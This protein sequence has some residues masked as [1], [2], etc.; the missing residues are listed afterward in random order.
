M[1]HQITQNL[2]S[3]SKDTIG[4]VEMDSLKSDDVLEMESPVNDSSE[5]CFQTNQIWEELFP[6]SKTMLISDLKD[7]IDKIGEVSYYKDFHFTL[8]GNCSKIAV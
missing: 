8:I 4:E 7:L 3:K 2:G 1:W 5:R 6:E